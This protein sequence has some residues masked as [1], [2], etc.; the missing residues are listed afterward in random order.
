MT[1]TIS[2]VEFF[3]KGEL[4]NLARLIKDQAAKQR[5]ALDTADKFNS[6]IAANGLEEI[7]GIIFRTTE[8]AL[9]KWD[10]QFN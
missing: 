10:D 9:V 2:L 5:I 1:D 8:D 4:P 7:V 6:T 3:W